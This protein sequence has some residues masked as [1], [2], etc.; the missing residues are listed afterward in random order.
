MASALIRKIYKKRSPYARKGDFGRLLVVGGSIEYSGSPIFN[1]LSALRAGCDIVNIA[2]PKSAAKAAKSYMPDLISYPLQGDYIGMKHFTQVMDMQKKCDAMVIG[3]GMGWDE[4]TIK[5]ASLIIKRTHIPCVI[6]ADALYAISFKLAKN[7]IV[8]PHGGEFIALGGKKVGL[9][10][11]Q[12]KDAVRAIAAK[13][14]CIVLLKGHE[15]IISDGIKIGSNNT[16][17]P[18]MTKG[19]TG[20]TL[21]GIAGALLARGVKPYDAAIAA[22][23]INGK[24]GELAARKLGEGMLASDLINEIPN[25]IR[26]R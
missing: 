15:D 17:S 1:A 22:A 19:G 2:A 14:G 25:V 18:F 16:G 9:S 12:K 20:D 26:M 3:G 6:D 24:A 4:E 7:F 11:S 5:A 13:F 23:Y 21:A 10:L 8:T